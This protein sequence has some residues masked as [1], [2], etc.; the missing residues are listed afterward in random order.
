MSADAWEDCVALTGRNQTQIA[1]LANVPRATLAGLI[2]GHH[3]ASPTVA[4]KIAAA[5]GVSPGT[6]FPSLTPRFSSDPEF[7]RSKE[8]A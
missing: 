3:S 8:A 1:S 7:D 5:V 6:L 2:G 4:H